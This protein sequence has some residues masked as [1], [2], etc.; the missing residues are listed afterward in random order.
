MDKRE[1]EFTTNIFGSIRQKIDEGDSKV[2]KGAAT[3]IDTGWFS[4]RAAAGF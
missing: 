2:L 4:E 1:E 3:A